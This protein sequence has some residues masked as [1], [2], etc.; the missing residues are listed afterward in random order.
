MQDTYQLTG[1]AVEL[2]DDGMPWD[3]NPPCAHCQREQPVA[4]SAFCSQ[5]CYWRFWVEMQPPSLREA[6]ELPENGVD[7]APAKYARIARERGSDALYL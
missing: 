4:D 5:D 3:S 6:L 1:R 2:D 7:C